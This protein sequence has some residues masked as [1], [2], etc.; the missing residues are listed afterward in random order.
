M[1]GG[2]ATR[3]AAAALSLALIA[4]PAFAAK[5]D[6]ASETSARSF[7]QGFYDWYLGQVLTGAARQLKNNSA[8]G[9]DFID[10]IR[11]RPNW[12]S[13]DLR[14]LLEEDVAAASR[15]KGDVVGLDWDPF[16]ESQDPA[17]GYTAS[18]VEKTANG[19]RVSVDQHNKDVGG[20]RNPAAQ[21]DVTFVDH[22]WMFVDFVQ[23]PADPKARQGLAALLKSFERSGEYKCQG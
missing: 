10:A 1:S 2:V 4:G 17:P 3:A 6:D 22:H 21:A 9:F 20:I 8:K 18:K 5:T 12:F 23:E 13:P 11:R 14:R 7:V 19:F 15:C 16:L